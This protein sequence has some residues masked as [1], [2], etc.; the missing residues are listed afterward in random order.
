M[1]HGTRIV[2]LI[3][4]LVLLPIPA[5]ATFHLASIS[6]VM[7]GFGGDPNIQYVELRM[8]T[9]GQQFVSGA[10]LV[11]FDAAGVRTDLV[12]STPSNV[13]F[14][15]SQR[16]I[17]YATTAF[18]AA[19][20]LA[21]DFVIPAGILTPTG[22][23][24]WG[25]P[26]ALPSTPTSY[27]DC[28]AYGGYAGPPAPPIPPATALQP[29]NGT[30]SLT[31]VSGTIFGKGSSA[32]DF[33]L[34]VPGPC[35][36]A[37]QCAVLGATGCGNDNLDPGEQCDDGNLVN[38]DGCE[39]DCTLTLATPTPTV[40]P[41]G[42]SG[43][44]T[45]TVF[46]TPPPGTGIAN[47]IPP[48]IRKGPFHI[49]LAPVAAGLTAPNWGTAAPG[50]AG[51]LFVADQNGTLWAIT[52][53]TG[54]KNVFLDVS[55]RLVPLGIF[56]PGTFDE[57]GFLGVAF[58]P[59]YTS[60]GLLYT[61][62]SE[63]LNGPADF[64]TMPPL[65]TPNCQSVVTEW[66]V[67]DPTDPASVVDPMS[68]RVLLRI[69]KPQFNHNGG[70]LNFG[71]DDML[72]V[73][74][75]DGGGADDQDGE[76][77]I[78]GPTVGHGPNGNG[79]DPSNPLGAILRIDP[80]GS[81]SANGQYGIPGDNPFVGRPGFIGEIF[82]YGLRNPWRNSFDPV[83]GALYAADVGQNKIE[84]VDVIRRGGN[85]GWRL[86]EGRFFFGP[87]GPDPGF[88]TKVNPSV[89]AGLIDPIAQYDHDE[90]IAV[91][92]GFVYRGSMLPR[93]RGRYIFG[94]FARTFNND[95]RLFFL[96]KR[97]VAQQTRAGKSLIGE[98]RLDG[99]GELGLSLLGFGQDASREIYVLANGTGTPFGTTGVVLRI[100]PGLH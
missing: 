22:M 67:P 36:N 20:G 79:Q 8:D 84:E 47:P 53:A 19:T 29:G 76:P 66:R 49:T 74:V 41:T 62:T 17:L 4:A 87:N 48:T 24:C 13:P 98:F 31:R 94:D 15:V 60:N 97:E 26:G 81:D 86:K 64:S 3:A 72:Y 1:T 28:A 21:P 91:I 100:A 5:R 45:P 7:S 56:G 27:I 73:A 23:V 61:F 58:H 89:P 57:R 12:A 75:G 88:V 92:G 10:R 51:R 85:Y 43:T 99:Q 46:P 25:K 38:G 95:G 59:G 44:P 83:T 2:A 93:L 80:N 32:S 71:P 14:G 35:N 11:V 78:D 33:A 40:A 77:F 69:D 18:Q 42:P 63:P 82:A 50:D 16:K 68:A 6:E 52:L 54:A 39:N 30:L 70:A 55:S 34:R 96:R 37:T 65:T 90:G 9:G